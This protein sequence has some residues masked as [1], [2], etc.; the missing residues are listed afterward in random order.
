[1]SEY[2]HYEFQAI[3]RPLTEDEQAAVS[4]LSSRVQL[5]STKAIFIYNYGDFPD[6]PFQVLAKYFDAL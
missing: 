4:Q 1:M 3:D 6:D 2:Q 5:S